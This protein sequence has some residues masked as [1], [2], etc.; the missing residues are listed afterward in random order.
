MIQI[1]MK[2]PSI[3]LA[4]KLEDYY[5]NGYRCSV[6]WEKTDS[7]RSI[8]RLDNCPLHEDNIK[9]ANCNYND[10]ISRIEAIKALV[11]KLA[12]KPERTCRGCKHEPRCS[13]EEPCGSCSNNYVNKWEER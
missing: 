11:D 5:L 1:D 6:N 13:H 3:C 7:T 8:K 2:M 12:M 4:C 9:V 10:L